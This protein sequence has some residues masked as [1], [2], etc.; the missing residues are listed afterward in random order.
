MARQHRDSTAKNYLSVWRQFNKFLINLDSKPA[1]WEDRTTLFIGHLI[2]NGMQSSSVKSYVS[3]IKK[4]L[5]LDGYNWDDNLV[6]IR[7]LA[8]ACKII[9]DQV[10]THLPIHCRLLEIILY[11]LI[12]YFSKDNQWYLEVL[13]KALFAIS[14]YG[15]MRVG[16]VTY[17]PHVLRAK[18][19]HLA[20]NKD[21]LLLILYSSKTHDEAS[22]PQKIKIT[23]NRDDKTGHYLHR[24][25]CPFALMREYLNIRGSYVHDD[26]PFFVFR[27][28]SA[29]L[30]SHARRILKLIISRLGLNDSLYGMHSFRIGRTTDLIKFGY[31]VEQVKLLGRW[32]SN[33]IYKYIR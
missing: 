2:N 15:L 4:T 1:L 10:R 21:K 31:S 16:E 27:D 25:F 3:A 19:V 23:S 22:R 7:S 11:E 28:K 26:E 32:K 6:L 5:V 12:R 20:S 9:N 18:N 29:V 17:S 30:P 24:H 14:Y 8:N 33:V 13:Y